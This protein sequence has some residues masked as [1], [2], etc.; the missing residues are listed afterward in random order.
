M[1]RNSN[2]E[3]SVWQRKDGRW[4]G[5]AYVRTH[6]GKIERRYVY[7][8]DDKGGPPE[9]RQAPGGERPERPGRADSADG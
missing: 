3:G 8:K 7:G 6:T 9:D 1:S 2:G 4:S 5:A